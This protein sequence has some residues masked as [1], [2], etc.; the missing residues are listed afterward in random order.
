MGCGRKIWENKAHTFL[1]N[2]DS[3]IRVLFDLY[4]ASMPQKEKER[5]EEV[6]SSTSNASPNS[7]WGHEVVMD[8]EELMTKRF[9][10]AV[11]SSETILKKTELDKYLGEDREAIDVNFDILKWWKIKKCRYHAIAKMTRDMFVIPVSMVSLSRI[12]TR[13]QMLD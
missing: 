8:I 9:E 11:G 6:S 3:N 12:S 10:M 13:G 2:L 1:S 7:M 5:D 4:N